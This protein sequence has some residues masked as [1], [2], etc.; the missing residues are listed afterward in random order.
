MV[1]MNYS[2]AIRTTK[3]QSLRSH[4]LKWGVN[5]QMDYFEDELSEWKLIDSAG[6]SVSESLAPEVSFV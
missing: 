2:K 6:Y 3:E 1:Q 4:N 5:F